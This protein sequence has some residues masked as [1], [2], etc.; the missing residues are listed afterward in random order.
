MYVHIVTSDTWPDAAAVA[1]QLQRGGARIEVDPDWV[2]LFGDAFAPVRA[3]PAAEVW[4][5]RPH[6]APRMEAEAGATML[7]EVDGV[8]VYARRG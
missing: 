8:D 1:L 2:F 3:S 6:E 4:F 5:L 7:G